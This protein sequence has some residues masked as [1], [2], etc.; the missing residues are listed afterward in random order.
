LKYD[1]GDSETSEKYPISLSSSQEG[2]E[3]LLINATAYGTAREQAMLLMKFLS[4]PLSDLSTD[5]AEFLSVHA[6]PASELEEVEEPIPVPQL[7]CRVDENSEELSLALKG[8]ALRPIHIISGLIPAL[9]FVFFG[10]RFFRFMVQT[11]TPIV[12][13]MF[14]WGFFG[15]FF[16]LLPLSQVF[17]KLLLTRVYTYTMRINVRGVELETRSLFSRK[18]FLI[19]PQDV[20]GFD[21]STP[22]TWQQNFKTMSIPPGRIWIYLKARFTGFQAGLCPWQNF[23]VPRG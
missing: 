13:R 12:V 19:K 11:Q 2:K 14:F 23:N 10:L 22:E 18:A 5:H 21:F 4:L 20:L 15:V 16:V 9:L 8:E 6:K 7:S 17:S 3:L 1:P